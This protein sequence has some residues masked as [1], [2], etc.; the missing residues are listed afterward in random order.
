[1]PRVSHS[2]KILTALMLTGLLGY[3]SLASANTYVFRTLITRTDQGPQYCAS[4]LPSGQPVTPT[5]P[6]GLIVPL[7]S[8]PQSNPQDWATLEATGADV[9]LIAI[10]NP[11]SGPGPASDYG[12]GTSGNAAYNQAISAVNQN[13]NILGYVS[14]DYAQDSLSS[15]ENEIATYA[16]WFSGLDGIFIDNVPDDPTSSQITYLED[17]VTYIQQ[18]LY[19]GATIVFNPGTGFSETLYNDIEGMAPAEG[20]YI[21]ID[22][23]DSMANVND[24]QQASWITPSMDPNFVEIS[25]ANCGDAAELDFLGT[26]NLDWVYATTLGGGGTDPY[27]TLPPDFAQEVQAAEAS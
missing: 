2:R 18:N 11:D 24:T 15:V 9:P 17:L 23:E 8:G 4:V 27:A 5:H 20:R 14:I 3:G 22:E 21:F 26:R 12:P 25:Y 10:M 13:A 7:Y 16:S 6:V 19:S 1:M